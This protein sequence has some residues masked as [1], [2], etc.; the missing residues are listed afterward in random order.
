MSTI[1]SNE[2]ELTFFGVGYRYYSV[3]L[4]FLGSI[5]AV[6]LQ[7]FAKVEMQQFNKQKDF[8]K[9]WLKLSVWFIVM[10]GLFVL[11]GKPSFTWISGLE[12]VNAFN[13]LLILLVGV[14]FNLFLSPI[15][16]ILMRRR[17]F[18]YLCIWL[19]IT[20]MFAILGYL[21]ILLRIGAMGAALIIFLAYLFFIFSAF[22]NINCREITL[23]HSK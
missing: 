21:I 15:V 19:F 20:I 2:E 16:N 6:L 11:F 9:S 5:H 1:L 4:L 8:V 14:W 10:F 12:Y 22:V 17:D 18:R 13:I 3:V 7:K 23:L